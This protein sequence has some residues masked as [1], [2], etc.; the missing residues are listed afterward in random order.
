VGFVT[1]AGRGFF[2]SGSAS[3][4]MPSG[5]IHFG[6]VGGHQWELSCHQ[7]ATKMALEAKNN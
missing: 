7:D 5:S 1:F 4:L 2:G 3:Q 6:N